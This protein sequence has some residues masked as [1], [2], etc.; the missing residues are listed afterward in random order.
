MAGGQQQAAWLLGNLARSMAR[1]A[2]E[3]MSLHASACRSSLGASGGSSNSGSIGAAGAAYRALLRTTWR[4][5]LPAPVA[6][7]HLPFRGHASIATKLRIMAGAMASTSGRSFAAAA[8]GPA[9]AAGEAAAAAALGR[10]SWRR[11]RQYLRY[12][13][14]CMSDTVLS[15][16]WRAVQWSTLQ[17]LGHRA[18]QYLPSLPGIARAN[19]PVLSALNLVGSSIPRTLA[20]VVVESFLSSREARAQPFDLFAA[21]AA[22]A[23]A[24]AEAAA[25]QRRWWRMATSEIL[26]AMWHLT[27][28]AWL[29]FV[30]APV[31]LAAPFALSWG[32]YRAEWMEMLRRSLETA[33]AVSGA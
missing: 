6:Q 27:R 16:Y 11:S 10:A 30:F 18:A 25:A 7:P 19:L 12:V 28:L 2:A 9:A 15:P 4:Q 17:A 8:A 20:F 13:N 14:Q 33:G 32:W 1:H 29:A 24:W 21:S 22:E 5:V 26:T 3:P 31:V 23:Q